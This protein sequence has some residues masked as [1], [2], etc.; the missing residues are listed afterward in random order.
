VSWLVTLATDMILAAATA[1]A[2]V[3]AAGSWRA[4]ALSNRMSTRLA[5]IESSRRHEETAPVFQIAGVETEDGEGAYITVSLAGGL[6]E[7]LEEV[8]L[9]ILDETG[10]NHRF[11]TPP[12]GLTQKQYDRFL[13]APWEFNAGASSQ[14]IDNRQTHP[15]SYSWIDGKDWDYL[16]LKRTQAGTWM[17]DSQRQSWREARNGPLRLLI[18]ARHGD[19]TWHQLHQVKMRSS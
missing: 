8:D 2:A 12:G 5:A 18:T 11:S 19:D 1:A 7:T 13:W 4:A 3:A 6:L 16:H 9:T 10:Q 17:S 15:R 14:V